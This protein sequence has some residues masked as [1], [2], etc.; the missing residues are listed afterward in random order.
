MLPIEAFMNEHRMIERM[1]L[2]I[3]KELLKINETAT[4]DSK[5]VEIIVDFIRIYADRCHHGKEEGILFLE[6]GKKPIS[7]EHATM[8]KALIEEHVYARKTTSNLEKANL[9]YANGDVEAREALGKFLNDLAEFYS[10]HIEKEDKQ[11]FYP[12]MEYFSPREQE[13]MLQEF[14][15]FDRRLVHENYSRVLDELDRIAF[16]QP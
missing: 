12:S 6:L 2:P 8:M 16:V 4:V 15:D 9:R 13:M 14:W 10:K 1:I 3:R 11:F 5:L 7:N